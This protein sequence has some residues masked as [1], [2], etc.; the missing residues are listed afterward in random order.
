MSATDELDL[1]I[2][3]KS[4]YEKHKRQNNIVVEEDDDGESIT[5]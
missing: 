2:G 3:S 1:F 4:S 5:Y